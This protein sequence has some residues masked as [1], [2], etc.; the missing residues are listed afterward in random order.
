MGKFRK[1]LRYTFI[2]RSSVHNLRIYQKH[3][4]KINGNRKFLKIFINYEIIIFTG[5]FKLKNL[6][7]L[8]VSRKAIVN[9][10]E[11]KKPSGKSLCIS[12]KNRIKI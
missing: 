1:I 3:R 5:Q 6:E 8:M 2:G 9:P 11:I 4:R 12:A 10:K 7:K